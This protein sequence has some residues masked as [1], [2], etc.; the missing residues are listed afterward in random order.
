MHNNFELALITPLMFIAVNLEKAFF[1]PAYLFA[2]NLSAIK[3]F[4]YFAVYQYL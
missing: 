3:K 1:R 2:T 4:I